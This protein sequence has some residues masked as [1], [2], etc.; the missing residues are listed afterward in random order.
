MYQIG[1]N[2]II[3]YYNSY[4]V[5]QVVEARR[6]KNALTMYDVMSE[7]G[8]LYTHTPVDT[9]KLNQYIDS[10]LTAKLI[11]GGDITT[12]LKVGWIGNYMPGTSPTA[13]WISESDSA[14]TMPLPVQDDSDDET[15]ELSE[16]DL[17]VNMKLNSKFNSYDEGTKDGDE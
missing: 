7:K 11:D 2:V 14:T 13:H 1:D 6:R 10:G 17:Y 16:A 3:K 8:T 4:Q 15:A 9:V 5:G 12:N